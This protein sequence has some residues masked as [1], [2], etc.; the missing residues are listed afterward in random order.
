M[1]WQTIEHGMIYRTFQ[2]SIDFHKHAFTSSLH[3]Q[4]NMISFTHRRLESRKNLFLLIGIVNMD[5]W[6]RRVNVE[7]M[8]ITPDQVDSGC[9]GQR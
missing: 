2:P 8:L 9:H 4:R 3:A 6:G 7:V 5:S 1:D